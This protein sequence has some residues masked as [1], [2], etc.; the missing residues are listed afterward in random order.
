MSR[1]ESNAGSLPGSA[2]CRAYL[3]EALGGLDVR[4]ASRA[5]R[6]SCPFCAARMAARDRLAS[7][8]ARPPELPE[9][10]AAVVTV[11]GVSARIV[12]QSS[13]SKLGSILK[14]GMPSSPMPSSA[15]AGEDAGWPEPLLE[16]RVGRLASMTPRA[17]SP[18]VWAQVQRS[19]LASI[20][21]AKVGT[22]SSNRRIAYVVIDSLR[23][24]SGF[25][26]RS[27]YSTNS[28]L[29][30]PNSE[31]RTRYP[32][33]SIQTLAGRGPQHKGGSGDGGPAA[34]ATMDRPHGICVATDGTVYIGDTL[35][36]RVR[37]VKWC[38]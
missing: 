10:F 4:D 37:R 3:R 28:E 8:L 9:G 5:H 11:E 29:R 27:Q 12:E 2:R 14:R 20:T 21:T 25:G 23:V 30:T 19:I 22:A 15:A 33:G 38:A 31:P 1:E 32:A 6:D 35:N 18:A 16:S 24:S 36:H 13:E 34:E 7:L 17:N 26:V